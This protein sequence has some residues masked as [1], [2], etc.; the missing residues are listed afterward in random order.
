MTPVAC[1]DCIT[2]HCAVS[3]RQARVTVVSNPGTYEDE[4]RRSELE[5]L[6]VKIFTD[7]YGTDYRPQIQWQ[8]VVTDTPL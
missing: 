6:A 2:W 8:C 1:H 7:K 4:I 5:I 3:T